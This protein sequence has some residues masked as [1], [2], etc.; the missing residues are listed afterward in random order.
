M[1]HGPGG[2]TLGRLSMDHVKTCI[3]GLDTM[4]NGGLLPARPYVVSGPTGSGKTILALHFLLEGLRQQ[5]PCLLV[6]LDEPLI[7]F[8]ANVA[9][10]D[11]HFSPP[12]LLPE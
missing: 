7:F 1:R 5:D 8:K 3:V 10:L 9:P 11:F 12:H 2:P 4:M 6:T